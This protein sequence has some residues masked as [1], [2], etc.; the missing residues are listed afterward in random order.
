[1]V[2]CLA[3]TT[4]WA[5]SLFRVSELTY[6]ARYPADRRARVVR[7]W[8]AGGN[9][10]LYLR[11]RVYV[12]KRYFD[13]EDPMNLSGTSEIIPLGLT[14]L[15][16][17]YRGGAASGSLLGFRLE[18]VPWHATSPGTATSRSLELR[19]GIPIWPLAVLS[20]IAP[21]RWLRRQ[22]VLARRAGLPL[23]RKC[24]YN[25]VAT[26]LRCPE[27]GELAGAG[28]GRNRSD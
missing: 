6:H 4:L 11:S 1:M 3:S 9:L 17:V 28:M 15:G 27:C 24:G 26:P 23:C 2:V 13:Y 25:L 21:L 16:A 7:L 10:G 20:A 19:A 8:S 12:S 18:Y 5:A 22:F 14:H